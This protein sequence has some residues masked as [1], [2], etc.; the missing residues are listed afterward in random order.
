MLKKLA[1][2]LNP[3]AAR[4]PQLMRPIVGTA[5]LPEAAKHP[6]SFSCACKP[7]VDH[8]SALTK[9]RLKAQGA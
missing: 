4:K 8:T 9:A 7:C 1:A 5:P 6:H 2:S 3:F